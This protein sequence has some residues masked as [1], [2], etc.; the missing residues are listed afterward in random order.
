MKKQR[1]RLPRWARILLDAGLILVLL[2]LLW[3]A[4]D[5]PAF[6]S[7]QAFQRSLENAFLPP[8]ELEV[9]V[10][11]RNGGTPAIGL[12]TLEG[13]AY[14]S[15]IRQNSMG[16]LPLVS[17]N[18]GQGLTPQRFP[19]VNGVAAVP[20]YNRSFSLEELERTGETGPMLAVRVPSA[21]MQP[22]AVLVLRSL[23]ESGA[24]LE[25]RYPL[26]YRSQRGGWNFYILDIDPIDEIVRR[27]VRGVD[28]EPVPI[29]DPAAQRYY[30]WIQQGY[31]FWSNKPET[32]DAVE[33]ELGIRSSIE[34]TVS[35]KNPVYDDASE[36]VTLVFWE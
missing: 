31:G 11:A 35:Y 20:L 23:D 9:L 2:A 15:S 28:N 6:S 24:P 25:E 26:L 17:T 32:K 19:M 1:K 30:D 22:E 18:A 5:F 13:W 36:P 12:G 34:L 7:S 16:W 21:Y 29:Q 27:L 3:A 8:A 4:F 33:G 10:P 14:E